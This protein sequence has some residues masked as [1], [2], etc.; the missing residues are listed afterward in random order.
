MDVIFMLTHQ[1][2]TVP[3]ALAVLDAIRPLGLGHVGFKDVGVDAGLAGT[4]AA[5]IRDMGA[6]SYLEV[7]DT[8]PEAACASARLAREIGVDCLL[9][10]TE[11]ETTQALLAG[12]EVRYAPFPGLPFGHPT[13]LGGSAGRIE[14]DCRRFMAA[15]CD[16]CDL[17]AFRATEADPMALVRAARHGLAGGRLIVAGNID[18]PDRVHILAAAGVDAFTIGSAVF[19]GRFAPGVGG[20]VGQLRAVQAACAAVRRHDAAW[21]R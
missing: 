1:D 17:L 13:R 8:S 16:G 7:V 14:A 18:S 6:V 10:G 9:G 5:R 4:L 21:A 12:S 11:V 19:D 2:R 3:D 20:V 15:G